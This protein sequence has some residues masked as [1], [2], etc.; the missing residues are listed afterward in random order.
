M[1]GMRI[2]LEEKGGS[3]GWP[4]GLLKTR[5]LFLGFS[6]SL[7]G[8]VGCSIGSGPEVE[9]EPTPWHEWHDAEWV[10]RTARIAVLDRMVE[11]YGSEEILSGAGEEGI[12]ALV[13]NGILVSMEEGFRVEQDPEDGWAPW[14]E[15]AYD[16]NLIDDTLDRLLRENIVG[17]CGDEVSGE[18]FVD[19]Y[20]DRFVDTFDSQEE[21]R[22]SIADYVDCG[23]GRL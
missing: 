4:I 11:E 17:W 12:D 6:V 18:V 3:E 16:L 8:V 23:D 2:S 15:F 13:E 10:T 20:K 21:Y 7:F 22:E 14:E 9:S 1:I 19:D 5:F